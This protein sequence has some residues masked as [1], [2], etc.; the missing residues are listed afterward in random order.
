MR[1]IQGRRAVRPAEHR[2]AG[3][4]S[5]EEAVGQRAGVRWNASLRSPIGTRCTL[6]CWP[7]GFT[8]RCASSGRLRGSFREPVTVPGPGRARRRRPRSRAM[9]G[10][11]RV[12][13]RHASP[14]RRVSGRSVYRREDH[15]NLRLT[16]PGALFARGRWPHASPKPRLCIDVGIE[17]ASPYPV[18]P[19]GPEDLRSPGT[20]R[21]AVYRTTIPDGGQHD[22][23]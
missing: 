7:C 1:A 9:R 21:F 19:V 8:S 3:R 16:H 18:V 22:H 10:A 14:P 11:R 23:P 2:V 15:G 5:R 13:P 20:L 17:F 4:C 12:W 6:R